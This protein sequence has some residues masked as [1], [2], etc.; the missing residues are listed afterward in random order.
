MVLNRNTYIKIVRGLCRILTPPLPLFGAL[1][2][3]QS[4][5]LPI[6]YNIFCNIGIGLIMGTI[7][8][9]Y[10]LS[11]PQ[12]FAY[13]KIWRNTYAGIALTLSSIFGLIQ[14]FCFVKFEKQVDPTYIEII[15]NTNYEEAVEFMSTYL[16]WKFIFIALALFVFTICIYHLMKRVKSKVIIHTITLISICSLILTIY[17]RIWS[18]IGV[19]VNSIVQLR[20]IENFHLKDSQIDFDV[21]ETSTSHPNLI[22]IIGESFDK[23]HSSMYG[24]DKMTNPKLSLRLSDSSMVAFPFVESPFPSTIK[25]VRTMLSLSDWYDDELWYQKPMLPT[26]LAKCHYNTMWLSNQSPSVLFDYSIG[27]LADLCDSVTYTSNEY[28]TKIENHDEVL[29]PCFYEYI[30]NIEMQSRDFCI[31]HLRGSHFRYDLRY[32]KDFAKFTVSDYLNQPEE[33]RETFATYDNSILYNDYVVDSLMTIA[34]RLEAVV[35][36][37]SDHGEDFYYTHDFAC[38]GWHND[39]ESFKAGCQVPFMIYFTK[40]FRDNHPEIVEHIRSFTDKAFNTTFLMNTIMEIS[41][42]DICGHNVF[43]NSLFEG[44]FNNGLTKD[45]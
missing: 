1:L 38:H 24:Y 17:F 25:A 39:P 22:L 43:E 12:N 29:I 13:S 14:L 19:V 3:L 31:V 40:Q 2:V 37:T 32:P 27:E 4:I 41:G 15:I 10:A 45:L 5:Q 18:G 21:C 11:V 30:K 44:S 35:I 7:A 36:Y 34:D 42:Y 33:R 26:A 6:S 16:E 8:W 23:N 9:A 28:I 20:E